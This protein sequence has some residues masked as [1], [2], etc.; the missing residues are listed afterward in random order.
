MSDKIEQSKEYTGYGE[1][2]GILTRISVAIQKWSIWFKMRANRFH[3]E[4]FKMKFGERD[5]DIYIVS[6]PKSGTTL[7]QMML[8]QMTT[9][10]NM[11]F[12]HIYEVSPWIRN[13][14][15]TKQAVPELASPRI[16]KSHDYYFYF[17]S[18]PK[19]KFIF[20]YRN[21]EDTA[22]SFYHQNQNYNNIDESFN[23][24]LKKFMEKSKK[25]WFN[26]CHGWFKNK[27]DF[28]ILY[29]RYEDL[30]ADK[31]SEIYR[32]AN[33]CNITLNEEIIERTMHR[34]SFEFMK[35]HETK[36][37]EQPK[38]K[39]EK[40]F[41]E[42]IRKGEVGK[43]KEEFTKENSLK[44]KQKYEKVVLDLEKKVFS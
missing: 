40:V 6:F 21:G 27:K 42:F 16:I 19:G 4:Q 22:L 35:T 31:K 43:G 30:M 12:D 15:L 37:G 44:F 9:D 7:T 41:N 32:M 39:K 29:V 14:S 38:E 8:Y 34:S 23:E 33:F 24:F 11:D 1:I 5:D 20:V 2:A 3:F 28:P 17:K 10:G 18:K 25:N 26:F 36:F 13:A